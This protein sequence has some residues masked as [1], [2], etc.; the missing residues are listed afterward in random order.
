MAN[1]LND[2]VIPGSFLLIAVMISIVFIARLFNSSS[3]SE[4]IFRSAV[5]S[6]SLTKLGI[7][8]Y[9]LQNV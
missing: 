5:F 1:C 4:A 9:P 2:F 3:V 7:S 8:L 6:F